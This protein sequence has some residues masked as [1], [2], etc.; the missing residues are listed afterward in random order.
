MNKI[1]YSKFISSLYMFR[2]HVHNVRRSKVYY[3]VSGIITPICGRAVHGKATDKCD[4][5]RDCI[6][7]FWPPN[8]EHISSKHVEA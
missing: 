6:I 2:A 4:D 8:N 5:T 7:Q 1:F 3:T